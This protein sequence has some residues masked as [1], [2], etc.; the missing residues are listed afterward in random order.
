MTNESYKFEIEGTSPV[1]MHKFNGQDEEKRLKE[2]PHKEQ[3]EYHAYRTD[4]GDLALPAMWLRGCLIQGFIEKAPVKEKQRTKRRVSPRIRI[5]PV[6]M[7][8]GTKDYEIDVRSVPSPQ[9]GRG[10]TRDICVRPIIKQWK[11]KGTLV[12]G[13][14]E[15]REMRKWLEYAGEEIGIGSDRID[16]YGRFKVTS[17]TE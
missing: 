2:L 4:D 10:G 1:M 9:T 11:A 3:A 14:D 13:L 5:E 12:S 17:F 7:T 15:S 16:G 6:M 8:L